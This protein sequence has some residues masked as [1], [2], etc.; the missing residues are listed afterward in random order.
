MA[1]GLS[2]RGGVAGDAPFAQD[3]TPGDVAARVAKASFLLLT[4]IY[5]LTSLLDLSVSKAGATS[6]EHRILL[7][8]LLL[9]CQIACMHADACACAHPHARCSQYSSIA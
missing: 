3:T 9:H 6:N 1:F 8:A 4:F 7:H 2:S 5:S